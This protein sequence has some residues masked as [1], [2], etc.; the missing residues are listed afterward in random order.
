MLIPWEMLRED[1][2][3]SNNLLEKLLEIAA[4]DP[5]LFGEVVRGILHD[6]PFIQVQAATMVEKV[7]CVRPLFLTL[8]KRL[9]INEFSAIEQPE[10]RRVVALLYGR[11]LWDEWEMK[12]VVTFLKD[13]IENDKDKEVR[14][15]SINSLQTLDMQNERRQ[16]F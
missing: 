7:T 5:L 9:M 3:E 16:A 11:V 8:Y 4:A 6:D 12:Q 15:N 13:W 1:K 14:E 2:E 10:V